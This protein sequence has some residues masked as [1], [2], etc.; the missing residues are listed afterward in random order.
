[1]IVWSFYGLR[2]LFYALSG[3]NLLFHYILLIHNNKRFKGVM[4]S[5]S[6]NEKNTSNKAPSSKKVLD[7]QL[8]N[9]R[10]AVQQPA[11]RSTA[12]PASN[13]NNQPAIWAPTRNINWPRTNRIQRQE[14]FLTRELRQFVKA[15]IQKP[16]DK[17]VA[18]FT[19]LRTIDD[20]PNHR[21]FDENPR[22]NR[23]K[24][25]ICLE[26]SRFRLTW[27]EGN[28][29]SYIHANVIEFRGATE[30]NLYNT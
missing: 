3:L 14:E 4:A 5:P 21:A 2:L 13:T 28:T 17:H 30:N 8:A 19:K 20:Q 6:S 12:V 25:V 29:Q 18:D 10:T 27:P 26:M 9:R 7:K 11:R 22:L 16:I 1:M 24:D 15:V 23:Y